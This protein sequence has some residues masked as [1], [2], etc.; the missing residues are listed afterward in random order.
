MS[1]EQFDSIADVLSGLLDGIGVDAQKAAEAFEKTTLGQE[2]AKG[3][4][5]FDADQVHFRLQYPLENLI[6]G[7]ASSR[8][9][10][11]N[12]AAFL[13]QHSDF[14]ENQFKHWVV[15]FE[16]S[17]CSADKSGTILR[18]LLKHFKT[19]EL[20]EWDYDQ[21][22][23]YHLPKK[24]FRSHAEIVDFYKG[25]QSLYYGNPSSYLVEVQAMLARKNASLNS[26]EEA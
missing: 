8:F 2:V 14:V 24:V 16:G 17:P 15:I 12:D 25:V 6:L 13:L 7:M 20:I 1:N 18:R 5:A 26:G 23:T 10:L 11:K 9:L 3:I 4:D 19:G 21:E 22:Y